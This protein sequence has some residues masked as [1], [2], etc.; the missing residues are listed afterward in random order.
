MAP[1]STRSSDP[2]PVR[3]PGRPLAE[4]GPSMRERLLDR[5]RE[6]FARHGYAGVTLRKLAE[7]AGVNPAL[8]HYYFGD[9]EQLYEHAVGATVDPLLGAVQNELT[10]PDA[11]SPALGRFIRQYLRLLASNPWL[12][13][14]VLREVLLEDGRLRQRFLKNFAG[15]GAGLVQ[16]LIEREQAA[17]RFRTDLDPRLATLSLLSQVVFPFVCYAVTN[18][19]FGVARDAEFI[20]RYA[21]HLERLF[22]DGARARPPT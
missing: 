2:K 20:E 8:I 13:S 7:T 15:R 10:T 19:V 22:T 6:L 14:L 17:G 3:R 1:R 16:Q 11:A 5:A 9:K 4:D 21:T 12:P 18:P